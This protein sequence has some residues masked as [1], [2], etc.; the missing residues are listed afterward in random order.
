MVSERDFFCVSKLLGFRGGSLVKNSPANAVDTGSI[1]GWGRSLGEGN[2]KPP[3]YPCLGNHMNRGAWWATVHEVTRVS[4]DLTT[5]TINKAYLL[6]ARLLTN[7][8]RFKLHKLVRVIIIVFISQV[9]RLKLK[10]QVTFLVTFRA[11]IRI[12]MDS[13]IDLRQSQPFFLAPVSSSS[14][15]LV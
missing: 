13:H 6:H 11:G 2:D 7:L 8:I 3:Q 15:A 4:C 5:K 9:R 12:Q 14:T 10:R 1:H